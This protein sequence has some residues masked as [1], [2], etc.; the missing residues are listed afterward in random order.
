MLSHDEV[1]ASIANRKLRGN[2]ED[3]NVE[4][5]TKGAIMNS[6]EQ[7]ASRFVGFDVHAETI[8]VAIAEKD[9]EIH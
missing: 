7:K 1:T 9:G 6:I 5:H 2:R 3:R 4:L 8:A